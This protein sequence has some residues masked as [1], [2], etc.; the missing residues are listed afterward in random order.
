MGSDDYVHIPGGGL[1]IKG[2]KVEKK[3]KRK[4]HKVEKSVYESADAK[5]SINDAPGTRGVDHLD[6]GLKAKNDRQDDRTEAEKRFD[7]IKRRRLEK[8]LEKKAAKSHRERIEEYNTY[9]ERLTDH[10]D[11]PKIGPG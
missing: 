10:N 2:C 4:V 1:K 3:K 11:M 5:Q 8:L 6:D 7:E 9:L